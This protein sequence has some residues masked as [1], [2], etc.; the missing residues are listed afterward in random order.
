MKIIN[1]GRGKGKTTRLLYASEFNEAPILCATHQQKQYLVDMAKELS[2]NIPEPIQVGEIY[3][4]SNI[5]DKDILVDEAPI[6]LEM[7]LRN[8]GMRGEV[9]AITLTSNGLNELKQGF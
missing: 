5:I 3:K 1:L 2:L 4:R 7:L 6:V 9:K 8:I